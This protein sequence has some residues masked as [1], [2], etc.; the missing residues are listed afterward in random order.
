MLDYLDELE[1]SG[2]D[3]RTRPDDSP[4]MKCIR[5]EQTVHIVRTAVTDRAGHKSALYSGQPFD[6]NPSSQSIVQ[7]SNVGDCTL[8]FPM[9]KTRMLNLW[10]KEWNLGIDRDMEAKFF[11]CKYTLLVQLS[12]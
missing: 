11:D 1:V 3:D 2:Y 4:L 5:T 7:Q 12:T 10:K 9:T 6:A 8:I